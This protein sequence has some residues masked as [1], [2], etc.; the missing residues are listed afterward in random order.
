MLLILVSFFQKSKDEA[1]TVGLDSD[2]I[3]HSNINRRTT[4]RQR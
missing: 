3:E 1:S 4:K 2:G